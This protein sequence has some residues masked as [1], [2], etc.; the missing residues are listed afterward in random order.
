M[1]SV[2]GSSQGYEAFITAIE[3]DAEFR[4]RLW[5][6]DEAAALG[7]EVWQVERLLEIAARAEAAGMSGAYDA[8]RPIVVMNTW[9]SELAAVFNKLAGVL[10]GF[11]AGIDAEWLLQHDKWPQPEQPER[12][13]LAFPHQ[14]PRH[15]PGRNRW[16]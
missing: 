11:I 2:N 10:A 1:G 15:V 13:R 12:S 16:Y 4:R 6:E 7:C 9:A 14:R 8:L 3:R 5:L